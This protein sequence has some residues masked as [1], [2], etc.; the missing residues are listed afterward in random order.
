MESAREPLPLLKN[1]FESSLN[2]LRSLEITISELAESRKFELTLP[3]STNENVQS[4]EEAGISLVSLVDPETL[5]KAKIAIKNIAAATHSGFF[6]KELSDHLKDLK[7]TYE[8]AKNI[9]VAQNIQE[10]IDSL[11]KT[12]AIIGSDLRETNGLQEII[13]MLETGRPEDTL[14]A[15]LTVA[16]YRQNAHALHIRFENLYSQLKNT[17]EKLE[18]VQK[19]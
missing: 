6:Q 15:P 5:T 1:L 16:E 17:R 3:H 4:P 18:I 11:I 13:T 8:G 9:K 19:L 14:L 7:N 10:A 2:D 12:R